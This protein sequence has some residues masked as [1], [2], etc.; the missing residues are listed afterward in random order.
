[1]RLL[2]ILNRPISLHGLNRELSLNPTF[3]KEFLVNVFLFF[4]IMP[5]I[6][7]VPL[8]SDVQIMSGLVAYFILL[9]VVL[10]TDLIFNWKEFVL[11]IFCFIS[12]LYVNPEVPESYQ[13]RKA[14]GP[15]FG[16]GIYLVTIRHHMKFRRS[17][18]VAGISAYLLAGFTQVFSK[19]LFDLTFERLIRTSKYLPTGTRGITSLSPEP[20]DLGFVMIY[21]LL[22]LEWFHTKRGYKRDNT[23]WYLLISIVILII[24]SKSGTG[25]IFLTLYIA[26]KGRLYL[27]KPKVLVS[28]FFLGIFGFSILNSIGSNKG[29]HDVIQLANIVINVDPRAL[30]YMTSI[31]VRLSPIL[32]SFNHFMEHPFGTGNGTFPVFAVDV[33]YAAGLENFFPKTSYLRYKLPRDL[34][35]DSNSTIA[36]YIF[37]YGLFFAVYLIT[38]LSMIDRKELGLFAIFLFVISLSFS[39]PIVFPPLWMLL[40][41]YAK[42]RIS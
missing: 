13:F 23:Y 37:E 41:L 2:K 40:G 22:F 36:K 9:F 18:F 8:G 17:T 39:L 31:S 32:V 20:G 26:Y 34:A 42:S 24:L 21:C 38:I 33:Y 16:F 19:G 11:L 7:P 25:Y 10:K 14:I 27:K 4:C 29:L 6:S 15:L 30:L 3:S 28:L 12:L 35:I 5:Y 1:M